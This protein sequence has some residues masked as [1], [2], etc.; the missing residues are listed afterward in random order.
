MNA[1]F[2]LKKN[3]CN[4]ESSFFIAEVSDSERWRLFFLCDWGT[5]KKWNLSIGPLSRA[6]YTSGVSCTTRDLSDSGLSKQNQQ[7]ILVLMSV[8]LPPRVKLNFM[9]LLSSLC[10]PLSRSAFFVSLRSANSTNPY[11][12]C[13]FCLP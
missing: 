1:F 9:R 4:W 12:L 6:R 2:S 11:P 3:S 8:E 13:L 7:L 10:L 5:I